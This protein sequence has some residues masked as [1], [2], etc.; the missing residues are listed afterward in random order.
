MKNTTTLPTTASLSQEEIAHRA[1]ELWLARGSPEG[2]DLEIWLTAER[3]LSV[4]AASPAAAKQGRKGRPALPQKI[5]AGSEAI[6][7]GEL[8]E[9]LTRFGESPQRSPTSLDLS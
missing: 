7:V 3:E 4:P 6:D 9:R 1:R 2:Q 5:P 8:Q